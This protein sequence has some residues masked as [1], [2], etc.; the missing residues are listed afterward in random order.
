MQHPECDG[1]VRRLCS[2][3]CDH[4]FN[5]SLASLVERSKC[6]SANNTVSPREVFK[7]SHQEYKFVCSNCGHEFESMLSGISRGYWCPFPPCN[8]T[9]RQL[10]TNEKCKH[11]LKA[12]FASSDKAKYWSEN[13]TV[14]PREVCL[15]S[16]K[17]YKFVCPA[18]KHEFESRLTHISRGNWCPFPP[19]NK[20]PQQLCTDKKCKH[21]LKA[22]FAS[23]DKAKYWSP[24]NV[25]K[26]RDVSFFSHQKFM[27]VC[28]DCKHEFESALNNISQGKW[29]PFMPCN[30]MSKQL[31]ADEKCLLCFNAS[32]ASCDKAK[33][34]CSENVDIPR[35]VTLH[36]NKKYKFKCPDCK[37]KF[38]SVISSITAGRWCP[39]CKLK[40]EKKLYEFLLEH[41]DKVQKRYAPDWCMNS[42]TRRHLPFD[43][44][45]HLLNLIVELDGPQHFV[46]ISNWTPPE[47]TQARDRYKEQCANK[48]G[49]TVI[50]LLQEDVFYDRNDWKEHLLMCLN[51]V[52][53][54]PCTVTMYR[55]A[56]LMFVE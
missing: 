28:P 25:V 27:F 32:F 5:K 49:K 40:T 33:Y 44:F 53:E 1:G 55:G 29:C 20:T 47:H 2:K 48:N 15:N 34:W 42:E 56:R 22:S 43:F 23:S 6:W 8:K 41:F 16:G 9:P 36:S 31:C 45:L 10:C 18:C 4:C 14:K 30:V 54:Q 21:C 12:S 3:D 52:Y 17:E 26:P 19:C 24:K 13:N 35:N 51:D 50:R 39:H 46:Q 7:F 37:H 38:Q 11:C